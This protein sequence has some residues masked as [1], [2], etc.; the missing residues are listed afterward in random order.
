MRDDQLDDVGAVPG[1]GGDSPDRP[2]QHSAVMRK[3]AGATPNRIPLAHEVNVTMM[4][5]VKIEID[6]VAA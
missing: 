3:N 6:S 5:F 4:L 2:E 1:R